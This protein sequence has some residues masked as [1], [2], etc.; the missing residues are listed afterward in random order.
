MVFPIVKTDHLWKII[1]VTMFLSNW[2]SIYF[3]RLLFLLNLGTCRFEH[4][5]S[6]LLLFYL[7]LLTICKKVGIAGTRIQR[8]SSIWLLLFSLFLFA[9]QDVCRYKLNEFI[10]ENVKYLCPDLI[11]FSLFPRQVVFKYFDELCSNL[12]HF[13]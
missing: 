3:G 10:I 4:K 5:L 13:I 8:L 7:Y 6:I 12:T 9:P 11:K 2:L 1:S